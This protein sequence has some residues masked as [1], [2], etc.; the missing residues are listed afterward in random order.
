MAHK[1]QAGKVCG[2]K[3]TI[4]STPVKKQGKSTSKKQKSY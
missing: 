4:R 3:P 2:A 1:Q